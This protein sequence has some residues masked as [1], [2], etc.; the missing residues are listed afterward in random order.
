LVKPNIVVTQFDNRFGVTIT[1]YV[2]RPLL[3]P[4]GGVLRDYK[5]RICLQ[6]FVV[7]IEHKLTSNTRHGKGLWSVRFEPHS[8]THK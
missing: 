3:F 8:N 1:K 6:H 5:L 7:S 4:V 2:L